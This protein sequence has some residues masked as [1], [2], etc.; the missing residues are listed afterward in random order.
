VRHYQAWKSTCI[1]AMQVMEAMND[2][3]T[4]KKKTLAIGAGQKVI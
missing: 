2:M 1:Q 4:I 3:M